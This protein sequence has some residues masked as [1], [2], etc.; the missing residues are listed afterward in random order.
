MKSAQI[1]DAYFVHFCFLLV[2]YNTHT[3][4]FLGIRPP[5]PFEWRRQATKLEQEPGMNFAY[6]G[7]GVFNTWV[8]APNMSTQISNFQQ[9][10]EEKWY[11]NQDLNTSIAVVSLAGNDYGAYAINHGKNNPKVRKWLS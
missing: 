7:T 10:I 2:A 3:A 1:Y 8:N 11:T 6:G 5:V 9:L 4:S